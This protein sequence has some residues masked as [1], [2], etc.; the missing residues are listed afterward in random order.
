MTFL[1]SVLGIISKHLFLSIFF[2]HLFRALFFSV[3]LKYCGGINAGYT[4]RVLMRLMSSGLRDSLE[5]AAEYE[6]SG[7]PSKMLGKEERMNLINEQSL[8]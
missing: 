5:D 1:S 6:D 3:I 8:Y 7:W 4:L 2:E